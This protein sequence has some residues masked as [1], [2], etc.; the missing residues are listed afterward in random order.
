MEIHRYPALARMLAH[1]SR[2]LRELERFGRFRRPVFRPN[3][4][5]FYPWPRLGST[6]G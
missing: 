6:D 1:C 3:P 4:V 2:H 5:W